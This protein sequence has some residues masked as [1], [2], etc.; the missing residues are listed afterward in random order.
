MCVNIPVYMNKSVHKCL[1]ANV[2]M[3]KRSFDD[4]ELN[5]RMFELTG[6]QVKM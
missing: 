1:A 3:N 6:I 4:D 5:L 2:F